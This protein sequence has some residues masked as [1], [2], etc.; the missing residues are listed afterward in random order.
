MNFEDLGTTVI[1]IMV[2]LGGVSVLSNGIRDIISWFKPRDDLKT[3]VEEHDQKLIN[4]NGRLDK[5]DESLNVI[6]SCLLAMLNQQ[7]SS[8]TDGLSDAHNKL[9]AHL[10][11]MKH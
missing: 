5:I 10:T 1:T 4:D 3:K 9:N 11:N 7:I 2:I 6:L 8:G